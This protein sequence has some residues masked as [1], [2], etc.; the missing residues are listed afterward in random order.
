MRRFKVWNQALCLRLIWLL[1]ADNGSLWSSWHHHH[2]LNNKSLWEVVESPSDPWT[3][4][5]LLHLRPIAENFLKG[6]I[7]NGKRISF[8]FDS[9][10]PMGSLIKLLGPEG[11][12]LLGLPLN[13]L[14]A[15]ACNPSGWTL[16]SP[17]TAAA[18]NLHIHLTSIPLPSH[19]DVEDSFCWVVNDFDCT[20]FSSSRTWEALRPRQHVKAWANTIWF[21]GAVPRNSFTMWVAH[22][23]RLPTR[24]RL[25]AWG[26]ATSPLCCICSA[27]TESRDHLFVSC[28]FSAE[29][30]RLVFSRLSPTRRRICTW[31]ELLSWMRLTSATGPSTLRKVAAH[32]SVYHIWKQRNNVLHNLTSISPGIIFNQIDREVRN[33]ISA[34]RHKKR[35]RTLMPLWIR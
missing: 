11:P 29:I 8:W 33:T 2:H 1:Y 21:K 31:S 14:V 5:M 7:G 22:L 25:A 3:W 24:Q 28:D 6:I 4:K 34:R 32:A 16:P 35:W 18:L 9:W 30:W 23:N 17:R 26:V 20:G 13:A 15:D 19:T 12:R 10:T 27:G